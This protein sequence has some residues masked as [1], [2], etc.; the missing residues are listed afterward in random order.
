MYAACTFVEKEREREKAAEARYSVQ[1]GKIT[2]PCTKDPGWKDHQVYNSCREFH[3]DQKRICFKSMQCKKMYW[4]GVSGR[5][6]R[7]WCTFISVRRC[8]GQQ[9]CFLPP[10]GFT[11]YLMRATHAYCHTYIHTYIMTYEEHS[12]LYYCFSLTYMLFHIL[13]YIYYYI[14]YITHTYYAFYIYIYI[15]PYYYCCYCYYYIHIY[16]LRHIIGY[17]IHTYYI[18][19]FAFHAI[20]SYELLHSYYVIH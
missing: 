14:H 10:Y 2:L 19:Y 17:Y 16:W 9:R 8:T 3:V 12:I 18:C 20:M 4:Y 6:G 5:K 7:F 1:R 13:L 15:L 11:S